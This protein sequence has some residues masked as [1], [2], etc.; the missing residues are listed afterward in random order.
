M[1][2]TFAF[3]LLFAASTQLDKPGNAVND[4]ILPVLFAAT[5]VIA[6]IYDLLS[7]VT[8]TRQ[9]EAARA[10]QGKTRDRLHI[11]TRHVID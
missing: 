10:C 6:K 11:K 9:E 8:C 2:P 4:P 5:P 3:D 7:S 1:H